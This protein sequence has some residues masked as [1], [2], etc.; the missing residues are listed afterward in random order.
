[1]HERCLQIVYSDN[2]SSF[3][4][5]L[6]TDNSVS[7]HHRNIQVLANELYKIVNSLSPEIMKEVFLFNNNTSL[8]QEKKESFT[9]GL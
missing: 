1:M 3:E 6:E 5:L 7:V 8:T 9:R 4:E 2:T